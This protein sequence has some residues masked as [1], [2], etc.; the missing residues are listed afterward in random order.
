MCVA[1]SVWVD[2]EN[3]SKLNGRISNV[4]DDYENT[5]TSFLLKESLFELVDPCKTVRSRRE[6]IR[7]FLPIPSELII[8]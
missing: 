6:L 7:T 2:A 5:R 4:G 3:I 1:S 8:S